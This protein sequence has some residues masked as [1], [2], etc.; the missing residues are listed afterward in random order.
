MA[1]QRQQTLVE[2]TFDPSALRQMRAEVERGFLQTAR[3][4]VHAAGR[5]VEKELEAAFEAAGA[6]KLARAWNTQV[7]PRR[8]LSE[9]PTADVR[10]KG[11]A[12]TR[13]AL[14]AFAR[15]AKIRPRGGSDYLFIPLRGAGRRYFGRQEAWAN[16]TE[17][18]GRNG[19]KLELVKLGNKLY[20]ATQAVRSKKTGRIN[21]AAT[22]RRIAK[23]RALD[24][25][26]VFLLVKQVDL[27]QRVNVDPIFA[28]GPRYLDQE[29][30]T[31]VNSF[32][33]RAGQG[34]G[35]A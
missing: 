13:G 25:V 33:A 3:D 19:K 28:R 5:R 30:T 22:E 6:G 14:L 27:E 17:W 31:R 11:K 18:E 15:G 8:G 4:S 10:G 32:I 21:Q 20:L 24:R 2:L 26:L 16:P 9:A 29:F 35:G 34:G 1:L 23:G 12:R 7:F